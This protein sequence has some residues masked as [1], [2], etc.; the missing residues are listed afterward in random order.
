L[1]VCLKKRGQGAFEYILMLSGVILVVVLILLILQG[2][3]STSNS[4]LAANQNQYGSAVGIKF[5]SHRAP[6]LYVADDTGGVTNAPCCANQESAGLRCEGPY[7]ASSTAACDVNL[8]CQ[9][10]YFN[11]ATGVCG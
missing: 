5:V 7:G 11:N 6:N 10:K 1:V 3:I 9:S 8:S 4:A 2:S